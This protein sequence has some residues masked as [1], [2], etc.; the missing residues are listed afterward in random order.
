MIVKVIPVIIGD[1]IP[2]LGAM[3]KDSHVTHLSTTAFDFGFV[4]TR[5]AVKKNA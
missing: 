5:Y 2:L 3:K 1:G 4:Q